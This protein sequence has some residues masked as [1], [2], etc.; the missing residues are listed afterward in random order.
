MQRVSICILA[1]CSPEP[2][3]EGIGADL[4]GV[5]SRRYRPR[6]VRMNGGDQDSHR[7]ATQFRA[8]LLHLDSD[9][10]LGKK[11]SCW[12]WCDIWLQVGNL[13]DAVRRATRNSPL[14][15]AGRKS[16]G[17]S[18]RAESPWLA[19]DS[20]HFPCFSFFL[21]GCRFHLAP[22]SI[23]ATKTARRQLGM[24]IPLAQM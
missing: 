1:K 15:C 3:P 11:G 4:L 19:R 5:Q 8:K 13:A 21:C 17:G 6:W 14:N 18:Q 16:K 23:V 2:P 7:R 9:M 20:P 12:W 22:G 10:W 24:T